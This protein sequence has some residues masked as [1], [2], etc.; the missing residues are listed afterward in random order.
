VL[1][2]EIR[3]GRNQFRELISYCYFSY[4]LAITLK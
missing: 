2:T 4:S 3:M 1:Q